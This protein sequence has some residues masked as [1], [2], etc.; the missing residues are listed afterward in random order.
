VGIAQIIGDFI[1]AI[2]Q[3]LKWSGVQNESASPPQ[4]G[5]G[6]DM[7]RTCPEVRLVPILLRKSAIGSLRSVG[8]L[9]KQL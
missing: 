9:S 3:K 5:H 7:A 2:G 1:N 6:A 4:S 8:D